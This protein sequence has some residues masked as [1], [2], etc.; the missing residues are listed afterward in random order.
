MAL[1]IPIS[2]HKHVFRIWWVRDNAY[3][4]KEISCI[5]AFV[6]DPASKCGLTFF[7][8]SVF[9]IKNPMQFNVYLQ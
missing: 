4:S 6:I 7:S 9:S 1:E 8:G 5:R 2:Y 3:S